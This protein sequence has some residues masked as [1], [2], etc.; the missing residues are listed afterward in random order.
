[1]SRSAAPLQRAGDGIPIEDLGVA[2]EQYVMT[3][4]DLLHDNRDLLAHCSAIL[5]AQPSTA[6]HVDI[7]LTA[8]GGRLRVSTEA[9]DTIDLTVDD[10]PLE[11]LHIA[12]GEHTIE[13]GGDGV[14][15]G[16]VVE[17]SG[18]SNGTLT[19]RRRINTDN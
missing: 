7:D 19:Q 5:A 15:A 8:E 13:T 12:D 14:G 9:I 17:V 18:W 3:R 1:M 2:G 4:N 10:H 11:S 16:S 6:M